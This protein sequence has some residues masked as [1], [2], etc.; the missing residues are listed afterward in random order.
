M[1]LSQALNTAS[2][3]LR[4]TQAG[5]SLIASNVANS[6]SPACVTR[7]PDAAVLRA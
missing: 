7:K 6:D 2:S 3:G 1:S 5:L 4:V